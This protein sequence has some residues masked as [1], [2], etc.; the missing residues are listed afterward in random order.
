MEGGLEI[1]LATGSAGARLLEASGRRVGAAYVGFDEEKRQRTV[2]A[3]AAGIRPEKRSR[4][5]IGKRGSRSSRERARWP[6]ARLHARTRCAAHHRRRRTPSRRA[7]LRKFRDGRRRCPQQACPTR[8]GGRRARRPI[9]PLAVASGGAPAA[10]VPPPRL[11]LAGAR[12]GGVPRLAAAASADFLWRDRCAAWSWLTRRKPSGA[13]RKRQ[14]RALSGAPRFVVVG[15]AYWRAA[16]RSARRRGRGPTCRRWRPSATAPRCCTTSRAR[17]SAPSAGGRAGRTA[18]RSRRSSGWRATAAAAA[19]RGGGAADGDGALLPRRRLRRRRAPPRGGRRRVDVQAR[20][21]ARL[22]RGVRAGRRR[23]AKRRCRRS[24]PR[25]A[26]T[27]SRASAAGTALAVGGYGGGAHVRTALDRDGARRRGARA[28]LARR[29]VAQPA[30]RRR[31]PPSARDHCLYV[32][33]GGG[34][35]HDADSTCVKWDSRAN[36]WLPLAPMH[37]PP[38]LLRRRLRARR[39]ARSTPRGGFEWSGQLTTAE[40]YDARADRWRRSGDLVDG[41][42]VIEFCAGAA[43]WA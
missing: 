2:S 12:R 28:R 33:G 26:P 35:G 27:R 20:G 14:E 30:A 38:P 43:V 11:A 7:S 24:A 32:I 1:A 39:P 42:A 16:A 21:G 6:H 19:A 34:N 25:A 29:R 37:A 23:R 9:P 3:R 4:A 8:R 41:G 40:V 18:T 10:R 31:S 15:G 36:Q 5:E 22:R 17:R 13:T